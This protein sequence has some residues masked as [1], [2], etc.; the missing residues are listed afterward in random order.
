M[1]DLILNVYHAIGGSKEHKIQTI[2]KWLDEVRTLGNVSSDFVVR[3]I[4][5]DQPNLD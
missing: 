5:K 2:A 4:V 1:N 3:E